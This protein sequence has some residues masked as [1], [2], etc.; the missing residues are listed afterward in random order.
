[1][2]TGDKVKGS[3]DEVGLSNDGSAPAD[4]GSKGEDD[5]Y[6][7]G[8]PSRSASDPTASSES[9]AL[10]I[11]APVTMTLAGWK[12]DTGQGGTPDAVGLSNDEVHPQILVARAK[13]MVMRRRTISIRMTRP[14]F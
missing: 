2:E 10:I 1:M 11:T 3:A 7:D 6:G 5:G 9:S 13:T 4:F 12:Q 14:R 8:G